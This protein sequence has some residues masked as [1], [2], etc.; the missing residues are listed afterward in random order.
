[1]ITILSM[2][3]LKMW[4]RATGV[5]GILVPYHIRDSKGEKKKW[6][7]QL[8]GPLSLSICEKAVIQ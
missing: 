1:M 4:K 7:K 8:K 6:K 3:T 5:K 2:A